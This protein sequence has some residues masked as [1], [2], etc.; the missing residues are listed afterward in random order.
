M[1]TQEEIK[2]ITYQDLIDDVI[3]KIKNLCINVD[4]DPMDPESERK[5]PNEIKP[6]YT[7]IISQF[8][9]KTS[10]DCWAKATIEGSNLLA[11]TL[12]KKVLSG[13]DDKDPASDT[14]KYQFNDFLNT[15]GITS[16]TNEVI[17]FKGL[18]NF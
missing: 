18:M 16:K 1:A 11:N 7:W 4:N 6:G 13:T 14:V 3:D 17:T 9:R 2:V 10:N 12:S 8:T 5:L 15:K